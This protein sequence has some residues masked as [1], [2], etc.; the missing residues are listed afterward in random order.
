VYKYNEKEKSYNYRSGQQQH[1]KTGLGIEL[2]KKINGEIISADSTQVYIGLDIGTAKVTTE[3][4]E[5]VKHHMIDIVLPNE[6]YSVSSYKKEAE[7]K[8]EEILQKGKVPIVVRRN[9]FIHRLL[10]KWNRI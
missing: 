7:N 8:I 5:Q 6:R 4:M 3:E 9:R 1:G 2:A 10:N